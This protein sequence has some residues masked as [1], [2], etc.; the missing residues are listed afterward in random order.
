M[1]KRWINVV[2]CIASGALVLFV[3]TSA[4]WAPA[5]DDFITGRVVGAAGVPEAG[6]W[7]IAESR[8]VMPNDGRSVHIYRKI[9][10]TDDAGRFVLPQLPQGQYD[11]WVRGYGLKDSKPSWN[12]EGELHA[13]PG[14]KDVVINVVRAETPRE[15]AKVYPAAY[16]FSL[17]K[18][19][20]ASR[21]P[22][23]GSS[24]ATTMESQAKWMGQLKLGCNLCHQLGNAATRLTSREA[25][26]VGVRKVARMVGTASQFGYASLME[27]LGDWGKRM[28]EGA[29]P[30]APSRPQGAE[31]NVVITQW[32]IGDVTSF[33]H[34]L[35]AT[36]RYKPARNANGIVYAID[37]GNDWLFM[38]DPVRNTWQRKR[39]PIYPKGKAVQEYFGLGDPSPDGHTSFAGA[40]EQ[41]S[42]RPHNP[43]VDAQERVWLSTGSSG[44][45]VPDFCPKDSRGGESFTRYDPK[46]GAFEVFPL[47]F[48]THHLEFAPN[49]V[50]WTC[51][52]GWFDPSKYDP[53]DPSSLQRAQGST[54][55]IV[56]SD[57]DGKPDRVLPTQNYG[58]YPSPDGSIWSSQPAYPGRIN[59][60]N[61]ATGIHETY[62]PPYGHGPRGIAVD[63]KGIVWT[64]LSGSGHLARF[65]RSKCAKTWGLGNQCPEGWTLW[66]TPGPLFQG[67]EPQGPEDNA[68]ADMHY[69]VW[70]DRFNASGLGENTVIVNGTGSDALL[71]FNQQTQT[72]S[73]MRVP[74][75]MNFYTRGADARIDDAGAGWKGRGTWSVYASMSHLHTETRR[76][77]IVH[78][79][80]RP[81][82]LAH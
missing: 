48:D 75:P 49:G 77:S 33:V 29:V 72:W 36:D 26:D 43:M 61:P 66:K 47:C 32:E 1:K 2:S 25:F 18:L 80:F 21:F 5:A 37:E 55:R 7:V 27:A 20:A 41:G 57:G 68:N 79:Q 10:V 65:D 60:F 30:P 34:D 3:A 63:S 82:P 31:R 19:P 6:V 46:T 14:Q 53:N 22:G 76:P 35:S 62:Q 9:V 71:I 74:Y 58:V 52:L 69:Y 51:S 67:F 39:I 13:T 42:A 81:D 59:Y 4:A 12:R 40:Y 54:K 17:L 70:V 45:Y 24:I 11:L 50:L 8:D 38:L 73:T 15:A 16:W 56:D 44:G 23:D 64:A 28:Q 78:M